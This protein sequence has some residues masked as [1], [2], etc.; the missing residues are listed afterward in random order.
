MERIVEFLYEIDWL[1]LPI[2]ADCLIVSRKKHKD[3]IAG[4]VNP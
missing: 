4:R 1:L 3:D 2:Y